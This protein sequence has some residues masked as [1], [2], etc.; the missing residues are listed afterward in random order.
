MLGLFVGNTVFGGLVFKIEQDS[1]Y[2]KVTYIYHIYYIYYIV[3]TF[4]LL[5]TFK[6]RKNISILTHTYFKLNREL[7]FSRACFSCVYGLLGFHQS[8]SALS[9][10]ETV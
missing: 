8:L 10:S 6:V 1:I 9:S 2:N 4:L 7:L 3:W 5:K